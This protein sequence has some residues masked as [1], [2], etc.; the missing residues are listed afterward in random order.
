M[1]AIKGTYKDGQVILERPA[2]WPEGTEVIVEPI[3]RERSLG[4]REEDWPADPEAI[5]RHLALMDR[6]EPLEMTPEEEAV[7]QAARKAQ[8]DF[9]RA[10]WDRRMNWLGS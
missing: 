4:V 10:N 1:H 7:W 6:I 8:K 2:N 9:E 3:A 5:D